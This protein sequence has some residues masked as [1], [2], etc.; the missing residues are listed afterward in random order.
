MLHA[1]APR[2]IRE[3]DHPGEASPLSDYVTSTDLGLFQPRSRQ[4]MVAKLLRRA[5]HT[6]PQS[7]ICIPDSAVYRQVSNVEQRAIKLRPELVSVSIR[8]VATEQ[9]AKQLERMYD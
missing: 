6:G 9:L 1:N 8:K 4:C 7:A 2:N 5:S 3:T